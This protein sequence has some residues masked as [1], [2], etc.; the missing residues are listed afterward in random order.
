MRK[1]I[2]IGVLLVA[3]AGGWLFASP[4]MALD[5][6]RD[7]AR[8]GDAEALAETID[9]PLVRQNLKVGMRKEIAAAAESRGA[10]GAL[11]AAGSEFLATGFADQV[12]DAVITPKGMAALLVTGSLIPREEGVPATKEIDWEVDREGL[13][14]FRAFPKGEDG[15]AYPSLVFE[16]SG[17]S[18]KLV[19]IDIPER[20]SPAE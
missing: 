13:G 2:V 1:L 20:K 8:E 15:E 19:A 7:A 3:L 5:S 6:L 12:V 9:F 16:R 4:W 11:A 14:T 18:W 17:L 10:K